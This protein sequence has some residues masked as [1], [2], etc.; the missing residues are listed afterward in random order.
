MA[1]PHRRR[2]EASR[3]FAEGGRILTISVDQCFLGSVEEVAAAN[4]ILIA[5]DDY[6]G[7]FYAVAVASKE[8]EDWLADYL[9]VV[10][11]EFG[12]AGTRVAVKC[13]NAPELV[14][15]RSE[16]TSGAHHSHCCAGQGDQR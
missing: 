2:S 15:L 6:S 4:P 9:K 5:Y 7:S 8:Y 11:D 14:R 10:L 13:D 1:S 12:Y 16:L 3:E